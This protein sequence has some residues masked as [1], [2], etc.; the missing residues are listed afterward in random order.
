MA[1][2]NGSGEK[3]MP[4]ANSKM[5][6]V[7]KAKMAIGVI[8][9]FSPKTIPKTS[10]MIATT[11][12]LPPKRRMNKLAS[13]LSIPTFIATAPM[14]MQDITKK[15]ISHENIFKVSK[16]APFMNGRYTI[17]GIKAKPILILKP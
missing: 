15:T 14:D 17:H 16:S 4:V 13:A 3:P 6:L 1:Y 5:G 9:K 2:M 12:V 11:L 7:T 10:P 8:K